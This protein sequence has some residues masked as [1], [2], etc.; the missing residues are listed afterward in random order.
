MRAPPMRFLFLLSNIS[1]PGR[2]VVEF[3]MSL[4][5]TNK[6]AFVNFSDAFDPKK[7]LYLDTVSLRY[8]WK[9]TPQP[10]TLNPLS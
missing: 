9:W 5:S 2:T 1:I 3:F 6:T 8:I 7:L 10:G 4:L